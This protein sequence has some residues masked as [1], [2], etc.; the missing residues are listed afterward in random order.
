M[1]LHATFLPYKEE[2]VYSN[3]KF[4]E[5]C[6]LYGGLKPHSP[7]CCFECTPILFCT[8]EFLTHHSNINI[9]FIFQNLIST[10]SI[11]NLYQYYP[12]IASPTDETRPVRFKNNSDLQSMD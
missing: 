1:I 4:R 8:A 5:K 9:V 10:S 6:I 12:H 7:D 11:V 3:Q 2:F